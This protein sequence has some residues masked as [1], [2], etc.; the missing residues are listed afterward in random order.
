MA[1]S[2]GA[3]TAT[4]VRQAS[5]VRD[6]KRRS[7]VQHPRR[8]VRRQRSVTLRDSG[9]L[10]A[11]EAGLNEVQFRR[12]RSATRMTRRSRLEQFVTVAQLR[13]VPSDSELRYASSSASCSQS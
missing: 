4:V 5:H 1:T 11:E 7:S 12:L 3:L 8:I 9:F 10:F 13:V 2:A 6:C